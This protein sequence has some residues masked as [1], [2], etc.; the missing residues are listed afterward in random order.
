MKKIKDLLTILLFGVIIFTVSI[1]SLISPDREVS[2]SERRRLASFSSVFDKSIF[3]HEFS[4][5]LESYLL[6]QFPFRNSFMSINSKVRYS[7]FKQKDVN[8]LWLENGSIF[9]KDEPLNEN[10]LSYGINLI[11]KIK[12][13]YLSDMNVYYSII[14]DKN[15]FLESKNLD[16]SRLESTLSENLEG[17]EY[18]DIFDTL[19]ISD[20]YKTDTHWSQDKIFDTTKKLAKEMGMEKYLT[21]ENE[22]K[23]NTLSPFYGVYWGQA[24]LTKEPDTLTYLTSPDTENAKVYGISKEI[25]Q[26]TFGVKDT[27]TK[28]VYALDKFDGLDSY[29]IFLSGAQPLVVI[30]SQNPR[31]QRELIIFRDS[32]SSSL[33]PLF[34]GAYKKITLVDLRYIPSSLLSEFVEFKKGQDAL[35]CYSASL[36]N[37]AMLLK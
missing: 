11:N 22:Y 16:Y 32:Y 15:Y 12:E 35:F 24:A 30:E 14:P 20:Y 28:A 8:G 2:F 26:N 17:M 1:F 3:S 27:L 6:D 31:T 18:I 10:Q 33:A 5:G 21:P 13:T 23:K 7:L 29:D 36:Y 34:T 9:K 37:S 25:L 19:K 4:G